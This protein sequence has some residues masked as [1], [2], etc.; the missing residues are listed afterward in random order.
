MATKKI[1]NSTF[2]EEFRE[3]NNSVAVKRP[4]LSVKSKVLV[5]GGKTSKYCVKTM[6][7]RMAPTVVSE[8]GR[9]RYVKRGPTQAQ[10]QSPVFEDSGRKH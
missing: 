9:K 1:V 8:D 2:L 3:I 4:C 5:C 7:M 6:S 10:L